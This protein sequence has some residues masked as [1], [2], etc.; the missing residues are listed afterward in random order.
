MRAVESPALDPLL[1]TACSLCLSAGFGPFN[2]LSPGESPEFVG[3]RIQKTGIVS[4]GFHNRLNNR[5]IT[6]FN[7]FGANFAKHEG[8]C[9]DSASDLMLGLC[10]I[11]AL[12]RKP[13][14]IERMRIQHS[15]RMP[16]DKAGQRAKNRIDSDEKYGYENGVQHLSCAGTGAHRSG[17]P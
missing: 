4:G 14:P 9:G 15:E 8:T 13:E 6:A 7:F 16:I 1:Q 2:R 5:A 10:L 17:T 11:I 3:Q 12:A